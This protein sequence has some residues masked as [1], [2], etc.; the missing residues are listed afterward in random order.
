MPEIL[1]FSIKKKYMKSSD[2]FKKQT[3]NLNVNFQ[4]Q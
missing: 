4:T 3:H 1:A 2:I